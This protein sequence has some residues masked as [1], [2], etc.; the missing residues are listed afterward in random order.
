M[1]HLTFSQLLREGILNFLE[2]PSSAKALT[3]N[4][5]IREGSQTVCAKATLA[6]VVLVTHGLQIYRLSAH[7]NVVEFIVH[8]ILVNYRQG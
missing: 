5:S 6:K 7:H 8:V 2:G 1:G 3:G 4:T